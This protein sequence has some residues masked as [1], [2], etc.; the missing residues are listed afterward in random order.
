MD[1]LGLTV[2]AYPYT[3]VVLAM[4]MLAG[5]GLF[6]LTIRSFTRRPSGALCILAAALCGVFSFGLGGAEMLGIELHALTHEAGWADH[7]HAQ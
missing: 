6:W 2:H 5:G 4:F 3:V 7:S 1:R